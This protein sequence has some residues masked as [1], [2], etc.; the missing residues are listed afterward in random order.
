MDEAE[1]ARILSR[2]AKPDEAFFEELLQR[3]LAVLGQ[4]GSGKL[5][6]GDLEMLAAAGDGLASEDPTDIG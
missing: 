2:W 5:D 1:I 3:C 4:N 6:D